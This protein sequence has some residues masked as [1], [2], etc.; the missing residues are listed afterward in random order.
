MGKRRSVEGI[1]LGHINYG[2]ADRI[3]RFLTAEEGRIAAMARGARRSK[4]RF[5]GMLDL[6]NRVSLQLTRG[7]GRLP[8][9]T[10]V[11]L[12]QGHPHLRKDLD[13]ISQMTYACE[14][15]GAL[16]RED[17][18]E[19]KLFGLLNVALVLL[20]AATHP[21]S[22]VFRWGLESKALTFAGLAPGL[23]A[24]MVC[25]EPFAEEPLRYNPSA[26]GVVHAH[27]GSGSA[28]N[29]SWAEQVEMA[30]RTPLAELMD[31]PPVAGPL[32][33][34]HDHL[35][36]HIGHALKSQALLARIADL[37]P[38]VEISLDSR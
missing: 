13:R 17:H 14:L 38:K 6:G 32:W 8:V 19:H 29:R 34:I 18:P 36:W 4:K 31:I 35:G 37:G 5:A 16:A 20:D 12:V 24:C 3:V 11:N 2:E 10:E 9:I 1:V 30:R 27:C 21:P 15:A 28:L 23:R 7:K 22:P 25:S 26:G 33:A